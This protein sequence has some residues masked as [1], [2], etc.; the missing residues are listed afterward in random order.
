MSTTQVREFNR[1]KGS[2]QYYELF[3]P[4]N[5]QWLKFGSVISGAE[6][7]ALEQLHDT[8]THGAGSY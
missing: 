5:S 2:G 7:S 4:I 6:G 3:G 1:G 8:H